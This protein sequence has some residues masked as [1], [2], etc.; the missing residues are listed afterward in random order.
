MNQKERFIIWDSDFDLDDFSDF[1]EDYEAEEERILSE[2]EKY[3]LAYDLKWSY[4]DDE[5]EELKNVCAGETVVAIADHEFWDGRR[6]GYKL[7]TDAF[8]VQKCFDIVREDYQEFYVDRASG[9]FMARG[10]HHDGVNFYTFRQLDLSGFPEDQADEIRE[11]LWTGEPFDV[12]ELYEVTS[13][14]GF[15]IAAVYGW[16][17]GRLFGGIE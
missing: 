15:D 10:A 13:P 3:G 6:N 11:K 16:Q 9:D 4:R 1:F 5:R 8:P 17:I 2:N 14:M 7:I 12:A